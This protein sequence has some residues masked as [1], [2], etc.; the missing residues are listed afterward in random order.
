M[1]DALAW[2]R[3]RS[4]WRVSE[5]VDAYFEWKHGKDMDTA[6]RRLQELDESASRNLEEVAEE[7][8][9]RIMADARRNAPVDTGRLRASIEQETRTLTEHAVKVLIGSNVDYAPVQEVQ[10]PYLRPAVEQN[11]DIILRLAREALEDA[12]DEVSA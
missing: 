6:I 3:Q 11:K 8:G 1:V 5:M 4:N 9:L 7:I 10:Q 12:A 2:A